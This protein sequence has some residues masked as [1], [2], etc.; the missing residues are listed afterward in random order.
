MLIH[1]ITPRDM[2]ARW[3]QGYLFLAQGTCFDMMYSC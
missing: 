1:L 2:G 3:G